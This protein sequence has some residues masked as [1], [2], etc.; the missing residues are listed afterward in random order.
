[1]PR[2]QVP[3][4]GLGIS[5][6]VALLVGALGAVLMYQA[7][8]HEI[9]IVGVPRD[10]FARLEATSGSEA[11]VSREEAVEIAR[12]NVG[13][14][15]SE[16]KLGRYS[17]DSY[18]YLRGRLVWVVSFTDPDPTR[19][20]GRS[21]PF[22]RDRSCDWA[23]HYDYWAVTLDATTGD[24]ITTSNGAYFDASLPPTYEGPDN[25]DRDYCERLIASHQEE[26]AAFP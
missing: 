16:A 8:P 7:G 14:S 21:G 17:D 12:L 24:L 20:V 10:E 1:M 9:T 13:E 2:R 23:L 5:F 19:P 26:A 6:S 22:G 4:S 18:E 25:S 11:Q 3:K 15:A